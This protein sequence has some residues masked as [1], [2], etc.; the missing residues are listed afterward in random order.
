[1]NLVKRRILDQ[2]RPW[3]DS[4]HIL[5]IRGARRAGKTTLLHQVGKELEQKGYRVLYQAVDQMLYEP[6]FK[7]PLSFEAWLKQEGQLGDKQLYLLLDEAQYLPDAGLYLKV[8]HDRHSPRVKMIISGSSSLELTKTR[9]FLT[10][11]K[12]PFIF[13]RSA[14]PFGPLNEKG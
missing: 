5:V 3:L 7:D 11:R 8:L 13:P 4:P 10:G 12:M 9:E 2:I 14:F 6:W 1:M